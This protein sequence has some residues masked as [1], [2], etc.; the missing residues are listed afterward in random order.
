[1][2][3]VMLGA[4]GGGGR[5]LS[6]TQYTP[7]PFD[8]RRVQELQQEQMGA[9][10]S[11]L[12]RGLQQAQAGRYG[13]L[14]G[15]REALRGAYRG[16]GEGLGGLQRSALSSAQS[17]YAPEFQQAVM[18]EQQRVAAAQQKAAADREAAATEAPAAG[19]MTTWEKSMAWED[20]KRSLAPRVSGLGAAS[21]RM[22]TASSGLDTPMQFRRP[23]GDVP[24]QET[25]TG[26]A[27]LLSRWGG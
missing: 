24:A 12:R 2:P 13:S 22:S 26:G 1:M 18:A 16:F 23:Y 8:R 15:R 17:L 20:Y 14:T 4:G 25:N 3:R 7:V 9:G 10:L 5:G 21:R 27:G 19:P 6:E 11:G